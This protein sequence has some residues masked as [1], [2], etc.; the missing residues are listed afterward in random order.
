[1]EGCLVECFGL[2]SWPRVNYR[3][4]KGWRGK[5]AQPRV[6]N[7]RTED[8]HI[9]SSSV[10]GWDPKGQGMAQSETQG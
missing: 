1:M 7:Q 4:A 5:S 8:R 10:W 3:M 2:G 9:D 6:K